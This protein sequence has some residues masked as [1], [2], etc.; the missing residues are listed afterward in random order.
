MPTALDVAVKLDKLSEEYSA[1]SSTATTEELDL[2]EDSSD[3]SE[4]EILR[5]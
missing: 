4:E 2:S 1:R 5:A 3:T